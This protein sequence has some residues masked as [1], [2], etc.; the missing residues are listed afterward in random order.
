MQK[1]NT[2]TMNHENV[3][4]ERS[5]KKFLGDVGFFFQFVWKLDF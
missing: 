3:S 2:Q 4:F 1:I 5:F